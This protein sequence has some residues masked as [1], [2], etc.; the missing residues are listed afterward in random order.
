[1]AVIPQKA[2]AR[3][4]LNE[5]MGDLPFRSNSSAITNGAWS[6]TI[7]FPTL[8]TKSADFWVRIGQIRQLRQH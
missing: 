8:P 3:D 4:W 1:M 6:P 2:Q 5:E 7:A